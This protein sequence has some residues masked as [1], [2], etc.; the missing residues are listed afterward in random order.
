MRT[1]L[2]KRRLEGVLQQLHRHR[3]VRLPRLHAERGSEITRRNQADGTYRWYGYG[4]RGRLTGAVRRNALLP[5]L[6]G[7]VALC[8]GCCCR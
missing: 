4:G 8:D 2:G 3:S 7:V 6:G 1:E 5:L